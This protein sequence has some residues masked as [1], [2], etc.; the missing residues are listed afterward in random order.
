M[1]AEHYASPSVSC[2]KKSAVCDGVHPRAPR[3]CHVVKHV[4]CSL[5]VAA[6]HAGG[7]H[8]VHG[9]EGDRTA[10]RASALQLAK[11]LGERER[12]EW[13]V[14]SRGRSLRKRNVMTCRNVMIC[15]SMI[16]LHPR[17]KLQ[18]RSMTCKPKLELLKI[19]PTA[20][21]PRFLAKTIACLSIPLPSTCSSCFLLP[22]STTRLVSMRASR[23][24][25]VFLRRQN[26]H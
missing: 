25:V 24:A 17:R 2:L 13:G 21:Y 14:D 9:D 10:E 23:V 3:C 20:F 12:K 1:C 15:C 16:P 5:N 4:Q 8:G 7:Q 6:G 18:A 22:S 19:T 11:H 26:G